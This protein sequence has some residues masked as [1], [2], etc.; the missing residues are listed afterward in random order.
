MMQTSLRRAMIAQRSVVGG[1]QMRCFSAPVEPIPGK[2]SGRMTG[3]PGFYNKRFESSNSLDNQYS[4]S[5]PILEVP[6]DSNQNKLKEIHLSLNTAT[7]FS[8]TITGNG[9]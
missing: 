1:T 8:R 7:T 5:M 9:K 2:A 4:I 6:V 3:N